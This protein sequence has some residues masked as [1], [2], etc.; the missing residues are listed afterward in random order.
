MKSMC[1]D[2]RRSSPSV[3][4]LSPTSP[5]ILISSRIAASSTSLSWPA[6]VCPAANAPR[7]R[8][9]SGGRSRLPTWSARN[10]GRAA[11]A[12]RLAPSCGENRLL[13]REVCPRNRRQQGHACG[14]CSSGQWIG[15]LRRI[16]F[17]ASRE[18]AMYSSTIYTVGM[19][20]RPMQE[21]T[22]LI[23]TALADGS[24]HG[25]GII[26]QVAGISGGRV[27]LR[28]GTLYTALDRLRADGLIDVDREEIVDNR[29]RRYYRLTP[30]GGRRLAA[31]AARLQANASIAVQR[32]RLNPALG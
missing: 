27:R 18:L 7:A 6:L 23:L 15:V 11:S 4:D 9:T 10:G 3:A 24:K 13:H 22:F 26:S 19:G 31:E 20:I 17:C 1:H 12:M 32:L 16:R 28:A 29:L 14:N 25:Y 5:C 2:S 30:E 21:A 8:S